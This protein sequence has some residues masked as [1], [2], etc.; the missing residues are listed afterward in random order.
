MTP[1]CPLCEEPLPAAVVNGGSTAI[2]PCPV[3]G[4]SLT[5]GNGR[6]VP[7][8]AAGAVQTSGPSLTSADGREVPPAGAR[9]TSR[10]SLKPPAIAPVTAGVPRGSAR[11]PPILLPA[12]DSP[13]SPPAWLETPAA[14]AGRELARPPDSLTAWTPQSSWPRAT[15]GSEPRRYVRQ[16]LMAA[17]PALAR[18]RDL[19]PAPVGPRSI[20]WAVLSWTALAIFV[21]AGGGWVLA[22]QVRSQ[23][24]R[25]ASAEPPAIAVEDVSVAWNEPAA[26][27]APEP[28]MDQETEARPAAS[29][30]PL[31]PPAL[32]AATPPA[33]APS[34]VASG[35]DPGGRRVEPEPETDPEPTGYAEEAAAALPPADLDTE[36][37]ARAHAAY[38]LGNAKL[39]AGDARGAEVAYLKSLELVPGYVAGY[40]GLGFAYAAQGENTRALSA[41]T[42]YVTAVPD[43]RDTPLILKRI[44]R[45]QK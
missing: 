26:P 27:P 15:P 20:P 12:S 38:L 44:R 29:R 30:A 34:V 31:P 13:S 37:V 39:F 9:P 40:R 24:E 11:P 6:A 32:A 41:F 4:L 2:L 10:P 23:P 43:A 17:R 14:S 16:R 21:F 42:H 45:L 8:P 36:E 22:G 3:C 5:C 1:G 25:A 18:R 33:P 7:T 28:S 19:R 35:R